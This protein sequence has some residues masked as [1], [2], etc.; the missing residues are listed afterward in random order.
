M[1]TKWWDFLSFMPVTYVCL[2]CVL[3]IIKLGSRF[4]TQYESFLVLS[5]S[6]YSSSLCPNANARFWMNGLRKMLTFHNEE[7]TDLNH[8]TASIPCFYLIENKC[9]LGT[10]IDFSVEKA[11]IYIWISITTCVRYFWG[12][13]LNILTCFCIKLF[14]WSIPKP[15]TFLYFCYH[16]S[17]SSLKKNVTVSFIKLSP[18]CYFLPQYEFCFSDNILSY[19]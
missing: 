5:G 14:F 4:W 11:S 9:V 6:I 13:I 2:V 17:Y 10:S 18:I 8:V 3:R 12:L 16:S 7:N 19:W 15:Q 1:Q